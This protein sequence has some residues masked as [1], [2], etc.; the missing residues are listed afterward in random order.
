M[1]ARSDED[2]RSH[3]GWLLWQLTH[4][5]QV[6]LTAQLGT[7]K[8]TLPAFGALVQLARAPGLSTADL[9]RANMVTPQNMGLTVQRLLDEGLVIRKPHETHGRVQRLELTALGHE[10]LA[11]AM[12]TVERVEER[13]FR[14]LGARGR[15]DLRRAL[16]RCLDDVKRDDD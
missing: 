9:A 10:S 4:A 16:A 2:L 14:A 6:E 1:S 11:Q 7:L 5:M 13:W 12:R 3:P 15:E 8:L